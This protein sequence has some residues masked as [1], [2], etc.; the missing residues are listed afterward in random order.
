MSSKLLR[1]TFFAVFLCFMVSCS[2][3]NVTASSETASNLPIVLNYDYSPVELETLTLI[4]NYRIS[5]GLNSLEK[6]NHIS[7]KSEQH[8]NYMI[9]NN[10]VNHNDFEARSENII[11]VLG[12]K[13][14]SE[15]IA[16]NYN[17]PKGAFD[18]WLNSEGHKQNIEGDFT[19]FGISI[20]KNPANDKKYYTII[21]AKI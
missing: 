15:N 19:H 16:Y 9:A 14:V 3:E 1:L 5:I 2:E 6:I 21:F 8:D 13:K 18:A 4:N 12:A 17:S 11:K 10:V 20:R 7:Y